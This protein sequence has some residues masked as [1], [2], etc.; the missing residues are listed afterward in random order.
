M[1]NRSMMNKQPQDH[2]TS[3]PL[4]KP[5]DV[6]PEAFLPPA[7]P[8]HMPMQAL[9]RERPHRSGLNI[10]RHHLRQR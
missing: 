5:L 2:S 7:A 9:E 1:R 8:L 4:S 6:E 3:T 10:L